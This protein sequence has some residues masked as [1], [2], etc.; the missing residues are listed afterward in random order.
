MHNIIWKYKIN[1]KDENVYS[2][3]ENMRNIKIPENLKNLIKAAN[4]ATPSKYRFNVEGTERILGAILS[5]NENESDSDTIYT[6][7]TVIKD[8]NL[9]PFGIDP[10]GNYICYNNE[11]CEVVFWEHES[12]LVSSTKK[13]L[14][15]FI[16][17]LY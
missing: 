3:I 2:Y 8:F 13:D 14:P 4:G 16:S 9:M 10:F 6:A 1:L 11:K 5:F 7:L 12:Y 15:D 17:S